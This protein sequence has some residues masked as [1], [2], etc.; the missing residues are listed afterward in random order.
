MKLFR[1]WFIQWNIEQKEAFLKQISEIDTT[2]AEKL[3]TELENGVT[4]G[5]SHHDN[6]GEAV[7]ED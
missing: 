7:L 6:N 2:F 1:E 4:N 5:N 3:N